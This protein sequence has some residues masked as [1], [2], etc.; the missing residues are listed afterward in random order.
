M[1]KSLL[2]KRHRLLQEAYGE[3]ALSVTMCRNSVRRFKGRGLKFG[4]TK[5]RT[6]DIS[7]FQNCE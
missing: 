4:T 2:T 1:T 3:D 6:T 7:E 5:Y